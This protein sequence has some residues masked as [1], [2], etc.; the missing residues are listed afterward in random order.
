MSPFAIAKD[1]LDVVDRIVWPSAGWLV[2]AAIATAP[3]PPGRFST[4]KVPPRVSPSCLP[5]S[6]IITSSGEP[7]LLQHSNRTVCDGYG[8]AAA[9]AAKT[10]IVIAA[11]MPNLRFIELLPIQFL[12]WV[13]RRY[14]YRRR[15]S[16]RTLGARQPEGP[17]RVLLR[18]VLTDRRFVDGQAEAGLLRQRD[19]A[20]NRLE[21]VR[22]QLCADLLER[23]EVFG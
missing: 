12:F 3:S 17:G 21:Q 13:R 8:A 7:A 15:H 23:Q 11:R 10:A 22:T 14:G 1:M 4:T 6:R 9:L 19:V 2:T 5:S 16:L 18:L 20:V